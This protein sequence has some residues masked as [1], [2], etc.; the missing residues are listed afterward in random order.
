MVK[1]ALNRGSILFSYIQ[2]KYGL[3]KCSDTEF[4][5]Q[6]GWRNF[7]EEIGTSSLIETDENPNEGHDTMF[8]AY[9]IVPDNCE[10]TIVNNWD[11][12]MEKIDNLSL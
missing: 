3:E 12:A 1:Y 7:L 9:G 8:C 6:E 4:C 10:P 2:K 11:E 5:Y